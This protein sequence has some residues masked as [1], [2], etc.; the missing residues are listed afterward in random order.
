MTT[1][2]KTDRELIIASM[3]TVNM[4]HKKSARAGQGVSR[5]VKMNQNHSPWKRRKK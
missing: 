2:G 4:L 5:G 1:L 3:E